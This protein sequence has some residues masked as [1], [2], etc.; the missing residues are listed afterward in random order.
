[1]TEVSD[2]D[3]VKR[4]LAGD[5]EAFGTMVERYQRP[6]YNVV[7][8]MVR[9]PDD[10]ADISQMAFIRAYERLASF[11]PSQRFFSWM[12]RLSINVALNFLNQRKR[13][14]PLNEAVLSTTPAEEESDDEESYA[15][16]TA[17][18]AK[19]RP[20]HRAVILLRHYEDLSYEEIGHILEIPVRTVKSRL[21]TARHLLKN[22]IRRE[23]R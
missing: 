4:C 10:A 17:A 11:D 1:M 8:R 5:R 13:T 22:L 16:L 18:L 3:L 20:D 15:H 14:E 2:E 21:F 12:Y 6:V 19:L 23:A 7:L 9:D